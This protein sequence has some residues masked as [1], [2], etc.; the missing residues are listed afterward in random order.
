MSDVLFYAFQ[1]H[2]HRERDRELSREMEARWAVIGGIIVLILIWGWRLLNWLWLRPKK[3][4]R[5][6]REQGLQGNPYKLLVGD[7]KEFSKMQDEAIS[8]P[9]NLSDDIMPRVIPYVQESVAKYGMLILY[10]LSH[11]CY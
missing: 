7:L 6:L 8:K 5:L 4:E 11:Y 1:S 9:M 2:T 3:L 10:M